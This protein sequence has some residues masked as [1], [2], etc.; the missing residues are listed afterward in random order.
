MAR[1][2]IEDNYSFTSF[3]MD[4]PKKLNKREA[5]NYVKKESKNNP[6]LQ[7]KNIIDIVFEDEEIDWKKF[8]QFKGRDLMWQITTYYGRYKAIKHYEKYNMTKNQ[9][10]EELFGE[11]N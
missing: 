7:N 9:V 11:Q 1:I 5:I 10:Y 8:S 4:I 3:S 2:I 6:L